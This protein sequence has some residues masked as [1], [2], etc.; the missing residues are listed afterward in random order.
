MLHKQISTNID[1]A[2]SHL[3][4]F[5][6]VI[7]IYSVCKFLILFLKYINSC[8]KKRASIF[9]WSVYYLQMTKLSYRFYDIRKFIKDKHNL[10]KCSKLL[11]KRY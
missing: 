9:K 7:T 10:Q 5:Y 3:I 6:C 11:V 8:F 1:D 2:T 4:Y